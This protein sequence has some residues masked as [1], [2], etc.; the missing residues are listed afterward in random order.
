MPRVL[1]LEADPHD[2][3]P[4]ILAVQ[5]RPP[6]PL[7]RWVL[8]VLLALF[9]ALLAWAAIGRLDIVAV[10]QGKLVPQSFL[11]VVQPAENGI[12]REILVRE[13]D[14]VREGQ[15]L[16]RMDARLSDADRRTIENETAV[17]RLQ[18]R[19]IDA[20][21]AGVPMV[22]HAD[23]APELFAQ[24]DAQRSARQLA[25]RDAIETERALLARAQQDLKSAV[26]VESKLRRTGPLYREQEEAW[27]TL[28]K[29]GFAGRMH[30][31]ERRRQRIENEQDLQAQ[32]HHIAG[33]RATASQSEK[34]IAQLQSGYRQQLQNER[35]EAEAQLHRATQELDKQQHRQGLLEL[36]APQ[37]GLVKDLATHTSGTVVQ[38]GTVLMTIVPQEEPLV[39]EV[40]LPNTDAGFVQAGQP[41][42]VKLATYPFQKYGMLEG[43]VR[44]VSADA[45]DRPEG[46]TAATPASREPQPLHYR[47]LVGLDS[48]ALRLAEGP[49]LRLTAGMQVSAEIV[50]GTRTVLEYLLSPVQKVVREAGRER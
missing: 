18:L 47:A 16:M 27:D 21:L 46:G 25:Q 26:E 30:M 4:G 40:W 31:L 9:C 8:G 41:A 32:G 2:F 38:P 13:G 29:E 33:L 39:A 35:V 19:R 20:E 42:R 24:V 7:P 14:A 45:T 15:V 37:A 28:A 6:S 36:R 48:R 11:K 1:S 43:A 34:R 12:V 23:D 17:R 50:L 44:H 49:P 5:A 3:S 10:A 22:R